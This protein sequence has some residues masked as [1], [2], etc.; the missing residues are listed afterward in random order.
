M[1]GIHLLKRPSLDSVDISLQTQHYSNK[2]WK[3]PERGYILRHVRVALEVA[4]LGCL[5][6]LIY[7]LIRITIPQEEEVMSHLAGSDLSG[8]VP[9]GEFAAIIKL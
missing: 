5:L 7:L 8:V 1:D 6:V 4:I 3:A 9:L 2:G